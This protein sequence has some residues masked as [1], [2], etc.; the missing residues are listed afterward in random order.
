MSERSAGENVEKLLIVWTSSYNNS[1]T[2][3]STRT[4]SIHDL[5]DDNCLY[6][7]MGVL[8]GICYRDIDCV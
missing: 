4:S 3:P 6:I 2:I 7:Y 1:S 8:F 5:S